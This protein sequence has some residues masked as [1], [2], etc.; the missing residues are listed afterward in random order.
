MFI[1]AG[2]VSALQAPPSVLLR[3]ASSG[4]LPGDP[5]LAS[6]YLGSAA[7]AQLPKSVSQLALHSPARGGRLPHHLYL[8]F[9]LNNIDIFFLY[10]ENK[11]N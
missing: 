4:S 6:T 5:T 10:Q 8:L 3:S 1:R 11:E 7:A 2:G 9:S